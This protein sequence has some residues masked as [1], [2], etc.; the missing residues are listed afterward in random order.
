V[1]DVIWRT[2][3]L[4]SYVLLAVVVAV[5]YGLQGF[6]TLMYFYF[7]AAAWLAFVLV[8]GS[9]ARSAG[10]WNAKRVWRTGRW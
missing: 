8:W 3:I 6:V 1:S 7:V 2:A 4:L 5:A 10:R 9:L